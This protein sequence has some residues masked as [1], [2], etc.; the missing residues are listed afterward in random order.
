MYERMVGVAK[1]A[2]ESLCHYS[3]LTVDEFRTALCRVAALLNSRPITRVK[4]ENSIQIL[5]P[6]HFLIGRLG[7]AVATEDLD[8][9]VERWKKIHSIINKFW[10]Q[11][12]CEY[13][14]LL[15]KRGK[16]HTAKENIQVGEVVLQLDPNTPRGQWKLAGAGGLFS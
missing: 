7:G 10:K 12:L 4:D 6:N 1:R 14:P 16:W 2:L 3:D 13:I 11:F 5:T 15:S 8:N 9:P